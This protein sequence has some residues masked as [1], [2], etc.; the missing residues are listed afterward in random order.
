M[1][2]LPCGY[3]D[4]TRISQQDALTPAYELHGTFN[5]NQASGSFPTQGYS[6]TL[7]WILLTG[8]ALQL[9]WL[10]LLDQAG[11]TVLGD[12]LLAVDSN[13]QG[14][15]VAA[16]PNLGPYQ[17]INLRP[18]F[19][20]HTMTLDA[21]ALLTNKPRPRTLIPEVAFWKPATQNIPLSSSITLYPSFYFAGPT[22]WHL[23]GGATV[24]KFE[25][26]AED[27]NGAWSTFASI[28][29]AAGAIMDTPSVLWPMAPV[30]LLITNTS[31]TTANNTWGVSVIPD[32]E[33]L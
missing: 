22:W 5:T 30:R 10:S 12:Q 15:W 2:G 18:N 32:L 13:V 25:L 7:I 16:I 6:H 17:W 28:S 4:G 29:P 3:Q 9:Q 23:N 21:V 1:S 14:A 8:G 26:Q 33:T 27:A 20:P 24:C 19:G 31:A 11:T